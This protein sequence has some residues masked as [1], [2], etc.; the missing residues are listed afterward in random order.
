[1]HRMSFYWDTDVG[2]FMFPGLN[3]NGV[4]PLISLCAVLVIFALIYEAVKIIQ[5]KSKSR[6]AREIS[7][8]NSCPSSHLINNEEN[9]SQLHTRRRKQ[10]S[11]RIYWTLLQTLVFLFQTVLGYLLM[12]TVMVY[13]G[14]VFVVVILGCALGYFFFGHIAMKINME[15]IRARK[16]HVICSPN[17][18]STSAFCENSTSSCHLKNK[19]P[20]H[21]EK[22]GYTNELAISSSSSSLSTSLT[23]TTQLD[24]EIESNIK[25]DCDDNDSNIV[26]SC[27]L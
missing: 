13:N 22:D 11:E 14:Y 17:E 6:T 10:L 9:Q 26:H 2:L 18:P 23:Q 19:K 27:R 15:N 1:M 25:D 5:T 20:Q 12:L 4:G 16:T 3:I 24:K 21:C 8:D 7:H